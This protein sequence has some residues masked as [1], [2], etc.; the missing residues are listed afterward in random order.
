MPSK[1]TLFSMDTKDLSPKESLAL[2][3]ITKTGY[4]LTSIERLE[5]TS[6]MEVNRTWL[7]IELGLTTSAL[8]K[9]LHKLKDQGLI[10][11]RTKTEWQ[12]QLEVMRANSEVE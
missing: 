9:L 2:G 5:L 8:T 3:L 1:A 11:P 6:P 12:R 4:V 10:E 7:A